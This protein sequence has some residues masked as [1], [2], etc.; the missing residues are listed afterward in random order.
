M[1]ISLALFSFGFLSSLGSD[2]SNA[3]HKVYSDIESFLSSAVSAV[4]TGAHKVSS[5]I[6]STITDTFFGKFVAYVIDPVLKFWGSI[7]QEATTWFGGIVAKIVAYLIGIPEGFIN[8]LTGAFSAIGIFGI[9][10]TMIAVG[11]GIVLIV[12]I[13]LL[14]I[15]LV[16]YVIGLM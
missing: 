12:A 8:Y 2:I 13:G 9:P 1:F 5:T 14:G 4:T 6:S 11:I 7:V 3:I 15:R 16:R 10:A